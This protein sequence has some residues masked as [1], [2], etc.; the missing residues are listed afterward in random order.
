MKP[1][2]LVR[3][4]HMI[5]AARN[6]AG[7]VEGRRRAD[8]DS[9]IMLGFAVVRAIEIDLRRGGGACLARGPIPGAG[10]SVASDRRHA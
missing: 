7:F 3:L 4:G 1:D 10:R 6:V 5:E 8:L 9:N 2:D